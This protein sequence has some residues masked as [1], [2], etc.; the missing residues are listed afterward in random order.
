MR[1]MTHNLIQTRYLN[2][3]RLFHN[4]IPN[5][6]SISFSHFLL[7]PRIRLSL[8]RWVPFPPFQKPH[9]RIQHRYHAPRDEID[10]YW[11]IC[12]AIEGF[13]WIIRIAF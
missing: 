7:C 9:P 6:T 5:G 11:T 10:A 4:P 2:L 8:S 13:A 3:N 12:I 1:K